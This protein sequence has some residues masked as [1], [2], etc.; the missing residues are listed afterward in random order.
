VSI[1]IATQAPAPRDLEPHEFCL[2]L[3]EM[4]PECFSELAADIA[5]HGLIH[6]IVLFEGRILD[7]RHRHRA[8]LEVGA[9]PFFEEFTGPGSAYDYVISE[10]LKRRDLTPAQRM[11]VLTKLI[12]I[13]RARA[14]ERQL[15][16]NARGAD[17]TNEALGRSRVNLP[18]TADTNVVPFQVRDEL[19]KAAGVSPK[20]ASDFITITERGTPEDRAAVTSGKASVSGKAREVR[21]REKPKAAGAKRTEPTRRRPAADLAAAAGYVRED[22]DAHRAILRELL[23]IDSPYEVA[24]LL[25]AVFSH[26][27]FFAQDIANAVLDRLMWARRN[28][29]DAEPE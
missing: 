5:K 7:G 8:C 29:K 10:N 9:E 26:R 20:T 13:M 24:D 1:D 6:P 11:D 27:P 18:A 23:D 14:K 2:A 21:E 19:A 15:V 28:E 16:G 22:P 3:P 25:I 12:D 4:S 17:K